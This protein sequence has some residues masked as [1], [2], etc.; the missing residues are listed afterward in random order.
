MHPTQ[1]LIFTCLYKS[2]MQT[3]PGQEDSNLEQN[4]HQISFR[5]REPHLSLTHS[6]IT[7]AWKAYPWALTDLLTF[8]KDRPMVLT[9]DR[10]MVLLQRPAND[11]YK[12]CPMVLTKTGLYGVPKDRPMDLILQRPACEAYKDRHLALISIVQWTRLCIK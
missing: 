12:N 7:P 1:V 4:H 10:L 6:Y 5:H 11:A 3:C 9:K 2:T 8:F